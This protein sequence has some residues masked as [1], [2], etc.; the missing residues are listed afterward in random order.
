MAAKRGG[1][2][3]SDISLAVGDGARRMTYVELAQARAI[4]L[5]S[6]RRL[7]RRHHWHRQ[8]GNDGVVRI[9]VPLGQVRTGPRTT[10]QNWAEPPNLG[11]PGQAEALSDGTDP[12]TAESGPGT[13]DPLAQAIEALREQLGIANRRV[14]ELQAALAE[15]RRRLI[16]I[17]T[18]RRP[19]WRRW[20]R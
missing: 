10:P 6:A 15:E 2:M 4:S 8:V 12:R 13:T 7:A 16:T 11:G 20:F 3:A 19:W 18:D 1:I 5:A 9:A 14:D 17:L